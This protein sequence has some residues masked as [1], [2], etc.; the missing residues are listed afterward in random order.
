M[1]YKIT[2]EKLAVKFIKKQIKQEQIRLYTAIENLPNGD[3]KS[4][5]GYKGFYRLR[6]GDFRIIYKIDNN[7]YIICVVDAGNRGQIYKKY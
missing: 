1:E 3:I 2:I 7:K 4:V 6:V 5:Q